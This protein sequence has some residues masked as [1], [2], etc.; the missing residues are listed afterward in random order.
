[1]CYLP[2]FL[3]DVKNC[4]NKTW[5][6]FIQV[7]SDRWSNYSNDWRMKIKSTFICL[8]TFQPYHRYKSFSDTKNPNFN[9]SQ[10]FSHSHF[11]L[12]ANENIRF[13]QEK[14][15]KETIQTHCKFKIIWLKLIDK[16]VINFF[17][18]APFLKWLTC[19]SFPLFLLKNSHPPMIKEEMKILN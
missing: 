7:F 4:V 2:S 5:V 12:D 15:W 19:T 14:K 1:M 9:A 3:T 13:I 6:M 8:F 11:K 17:I 10:I 16:S 18:N